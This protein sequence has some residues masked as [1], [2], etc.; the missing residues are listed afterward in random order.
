MLIPLC[1]ALACAPQGSD[2]AQVAFEAWTEDAVTLIGQLEGM[3]P[4]PF[5]GCPREEFDRGVDEFLGGLE[6]AS[7][8]QALA[9]FMRLFA[10]LSAH[11]RE[12]HSVVWPL[13]GHVLP[14]TLYG[15]ADGWFVVDAEGPVR[16]HV[17]ARVTAIGGV[18]IEEACARVTPLLTRDNDWNLRFKLPFALATVEILDGVGLAEGPDRVRLSLEQDGK[19]QDI[20]VQGAPGMSF[21]HVALP[22][23]GGAIWLEGHEEAFRLKVLEPEHALYVQYNQ[24]VPQA[25]DGRLLDDF[26]QEI[27]RVFEER[28]LAKVI[29]DVR[30]NGGGDNTTFGPLIRALQTPSIDRPGVLFGLIGRATFSAAGN[31]V[32]VLQRDTKAIL[33]GEPTGGAPN[34]YGDARSVELP[35]HPG[36]LVRIATRYHEFS[37]SDDARLTHEPHR[38]VPLRSEDYFAGRDPVLRAALDYQAPR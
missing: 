15:F 27:V 16:R 30:C 8:N 17:G 1:L 14:L 24:V 35:R 9:G 23:Q 19:P 13:H 37:T 20:S 2:D 29:V 22:P 10:R 4:D 5:F 18:P 12:G 28:G 21:T 25:S 38:A 33:L 26:A 6:G 11:G 3:H 32:T 36:L 7:E 34:Q 31:F